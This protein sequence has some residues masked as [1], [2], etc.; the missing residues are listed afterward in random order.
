MAD[1]EF[2]TGARFRMHGFTGNGAA[3]PFVSFKIGQWS[4]AEISLHLEVDEARELARA[5]EAA[6]DFASGPRV[7]T[8][9]DLGCEVL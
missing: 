8:A 6:A 9:A 1:K 2:R 4:V 3:S 5:L 7:G